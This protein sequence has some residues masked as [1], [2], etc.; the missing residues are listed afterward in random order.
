MASFVGIRSVRIFV[1][2]HLFRQ[3]ILPFRR[4]GKHVVLQVDGDGRVFYVALALY[5]FDD[6]L[7]RERPFTLQ[8][9]GNDVAHNA[10][11]VAPLFQGVESAADEDKAVVLDEFVVRR[12]RMRLAA[13]KFFDVFGDFDK[14][15]SEEHTSK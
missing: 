14:M 4:F 12:R 7:A 10:R 5:T 2:W 3:R 15:R 1:D 9:T 6:L 11:F 8:D 13:K